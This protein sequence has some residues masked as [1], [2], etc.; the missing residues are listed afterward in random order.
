MISIVIPAYN[1]EK[2]VEQT[3]RQFKALAVPHEVIVSDTASTDRT[4]AVARAC[5]D[6]VVMLPEH[7]KRDASTGRN[8]GAMAAE[9][10]YIVFLDCGTMIPDPNEFFDKALARFLRKP[11]LAGISVRIEVEPPVRTKSDAAVSFLMNAWF[12]FLNN[13]AGVGI[14]SGK[15]QMVPR[16][17]FLK[18]GGFRETLATAEDV[19]FFGRLR[20]FGRTEIV[21]E[22][23]AYHSGRRFHELGAWR[24]LFRWIKNAVSFWL[25]KKP[26]DEWEPVR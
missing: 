7:K 17:I 14:A 11:G 21:W 19:D 5:A 25:F 18:S 2:T 24:T 10:E 20:K 22:L 15:F 4:V 12:L 16:T 1:E 9:G 13:A 23:A 3:V 26:S 6:K 8:G